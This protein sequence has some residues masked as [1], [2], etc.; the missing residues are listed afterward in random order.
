MAKGRNVFVCQECGY[1]SPGFLGKC[2]A[3]ER[4]GTLV[5]EVQVKETSSKKSTIKDTKPLSLSQISSNNEDR[6]STGLLELDRVLGGGIVKGS[7]IL[8]GG[9]PGIGKSTLLLQICNSLKADVN[10]L[11]VSGEESVGQIKMRAERLGVNRDQLKLLSENSL[12]AITAVVEN[13]QPQL[14]MVD[15]IQTVYCED[16]TSAPGSVSQVREA[17]SR[18]MHIAKKMGIATIIVGHVT[19]EGNIAGPKVLEHMVD[20]VLYFEGER[21]FAYRILRAIKNRFGSTNE[22]GMFEMKE[23]GL[24]E[25][26]EMSNILLSERS[27]DVPGSVI[28]ASI[29]GSR[30]ILAEIQALVSQTPFGMPRR[31]ANGLDYNRVVLLAAVL[32][33]RLGLNLSNQDIYVNVVGG[34]R[35]DEPAVDLAI[36][37]AIT[38]SFKNKRVNPK[39]VIVGEVGLTGEVRTIHN[40]EKRLNEAEKMGFKQCIIPFGNIKLIGKKNTIAVTGVKDI[41]EAVESVIVN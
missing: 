31:M 27:N 4:W 32:E 12:E 36:M 14:L 33:K 3:C 10:I 28:V 13:T 23:E 11:Y 21:H 20:C 7:L 35:L 2:P 19:K 37:M 41:R 40:I 16:L 15:S 8:V 34:I 17:T 26:K 30:P 18:L 29:E 24:V 9:D 22:I 38:S 1:E 39:A 25:V 6:M 5:E